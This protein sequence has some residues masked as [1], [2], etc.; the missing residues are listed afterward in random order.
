[1]LAARTGKFVNVVA[2]ID[3][4]R[5][6]GKILYVNPASVTITPDANAAGGMPV[7]SPFAAFELSVLD[8]AGSELLRVRPTVQASRCEGEVPD[9]ALV[10]Q[11]LPLAAGMKTVVLLHNNAEIDRYEAGAPQPAV[12]GA[13]AAAGG[14]APLNAGLPVPGK[15][16]KLPLSVAGAAPAQAGISYTV[17]VRPQ[18]SSAWQTIAV[19]RKQAS[20]NLDRNQFSGAGK[21]TVRVLRTNGFEDEVIAEQDVD[22]DK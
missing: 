18:G 10:D 15:P 14:M 19:G 3:R 2:S 22:L 12:L 11:A 1:M 20:V 8:A 6:Q 7:A 9:T 4:V 16:H 13:A 5:G 21:A 17:Q